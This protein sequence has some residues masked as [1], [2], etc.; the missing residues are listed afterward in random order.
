[1]AR[2]RSMA[3]ARI[4]ARLRLTDVVEDAQRLAAGRRGLLGADHD[5]DRLVAIGGDA[6]GAGIFGAEGKQPADL[7]ET[8]FVERRGE[9]VVEQG[10]GVHRSPLAGRRE[11][12]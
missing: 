5:L 11:R 8:Q 2:A 3:S 4:F 10:R 6:G 1:M 7:A 12:G 9:L